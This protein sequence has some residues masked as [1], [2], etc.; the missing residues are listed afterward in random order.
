MAEEVDA[1]PILA[2]KEDQLKADETTDS[3]LTILNTLGGKLV[4]DVI[5]KYETLKPVAQDESAASMT[6]R[7]IKQ[8]GYIDLANLPSPENLD[9]MIRAFHPWPSVWTCVVLRSHLVQGETL[10]KERVVKFLPQQKLQ[11]E[12][13]KPMS[14]KDFINGY[15]QM[16]EMMHK[17]GFQV[18]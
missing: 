1:G 18:Q 15:P 17:L 13:G 14:I 5:K 12:G 3:L 10:Q 11:V 8:D 4:V 2:Q 9:R 16:K 7:M 6:R